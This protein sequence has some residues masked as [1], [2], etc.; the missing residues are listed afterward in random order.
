MN[1]LVLFNNADAPGNVYYGVNPRL[2]STGNNLADVP[3]YNAF[4][5]DCDD[6]K[7]H[8]IQDRWRQILL[9]IKAGIP[10][11]F[12]IF[13]GHGF[14]PYWLLQ[15][16]IAAEAGR[17]ILKPM[18]KLAGCK[19]KGN[20]FDST[21]VLRLPGFNN[22]KNWFGTPPETPPC[23]IVYPQD[24]AQRDPLDPNHI[25]IY[26]PNVFKQFPPS[27]KHDLARYASHAATISG[28]QSLDDKVALVMSEAM[29][30]IIQQQVQSTGQAIAAENL[31][32][33]GVA[34]T[35]EP[36]P[37]VNQKTT[38][39]PPEEI[40]WRRG[41]TWMKK[42]IQL[43]YAGLR[44]DQIDE[45]AERIKS[46][47]RS[48]SAFDFKIML[49][50]V[51]MNYTY[52][53]IKAFWY[54]SDTKLHRPDKE[55]RNP[56][57][58]DMSYGKCVEVSK[59]IID[60]AATS[61][62][63]NNQKVRE[64]EYT[65]IDKNTGQ[66]FQAYKTEYLIG[67]KYVEMLNC[68]LSIEVIYENPYAVGEEEPTHYALSIEC[69]EVRRATTIVPRN[70]FSSATKLR[71]LPLVCYYIDSAGALQHL[72]EFLIARCTRPIKRL[73]DKVFYK[74]GFYD[75]P[76]Y[77]VTENEIEKTVQSD[78]DKLMVD[79]L[80]RRNEF[81]DAFL[82]EIKPREETIALI[83]EM[84]PK[85][86]HLHA[87]ELLLPV[88][89]VIGACALRPLL[90][91]KCDVQL[92]VPTIN[93]RGAASRG[94]SHTV[95][96]LMQLCGFKN[97]DKT[98][99]FSV[100]G[101]SVF[102]FSKI[103]GATNM[104]PIAVDEFKEEGNN[105]NQL[106]NFR[107][108]IRRIFT[109]E[110]AGKGRADL[111]YNI[112]RLRGTMVVTGETPLERSDNPAEVSRI[113]PIDV[114]GDVANSA[115]VAEYF[116]DKSIGHISPH[117]YQFLLKQD[118]RALLRELNGLRRTA[119]A[120]L[121]N[122]A[123]EK[124]RVAP[125]VAI[126]QMGIRMFDRFVKTID[127]AMPSLEETLDFDKNFIQKL[128][129]HVNMSEHTVQYQD[130][131]T[132]ESK[133][134]SRDEAIDFLSTLFEL[135]EIRSDEWVKSHEKNAF[136][137]QENKKKDEAYIHFKTA[138]DVYRTYCRRIGK[139]NVLKEK[140]K[141]MFVQEQPYL[142]HRSKVVRAATPQTAEHEKPIT[143]TIGVMVFS[144]SK[145]IEMG[146][147]PNLELTPEDKVEIDQE[148]STALQVAGEVGENA[149]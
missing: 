69:S 84:W 8:T 29:K 114:Y 13:T 101:T 63:T 17:N 144:R 113:I 87:P 19:D 55:A 145:L 141:R 104:I 147:I 73:H 79:Y 137:L 21:R 80:I 27:E 130:E 30:T 118:A 94:K 85:I 12:V 54:R 123:Q 43:G 66:P 91:H 131:I 9:W 10:P 71:S 68:R 111:S 90:E 125:N 109:G 40:T 97:L 128:N 6:N 142:L 59:N 3:Y 70:Y 18:V 62:A 149:F 117:F 127:P 56:G 136:V 148:A 53:A 134:K 16:Q 82:Q 76:Y 38:I 138:Y 50:L 52:E 119:A 37:A 75:F 95:K 61:A 140:I 4:Y 31:D 133:V 89:G 67:E 143:I 45:I 132:G 34:S 78:F 99:M 129:E 93:V 115:E 60:A 49:E 25:S 42:Y 107:S 47:D 100:M 28:D 58:F 26:D 5:L 126:I 92:E 86:L 110:T 77:R 81:A 11:S 48:A 20:T 112:S 23:A 7:S 46:S 57:Y 124:N 120:K 64:I 41:R 96:I 103:L 108:L 122:F 83:K 135:R 65:I 88:I 44:Q 15:Y 35:N 72:Q 39:P 51:L 32:R 98:H 14:H 106:E 74:D 1:R 36:A 33:S 116:K 146:I 24:W 121:V 105:D 22:V 139:K 102:A 2:S